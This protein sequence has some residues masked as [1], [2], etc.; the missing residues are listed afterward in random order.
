MSDYNF[1]CQ[2]CECNFDQLMWDRGLPPVC[3]KCDSDN[4]IST[5]LAEENARINAQEAWA[6]GWQE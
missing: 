1:H 5:E 4:I 2:D 3:P 6:E